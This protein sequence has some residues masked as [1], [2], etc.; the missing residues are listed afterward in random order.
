MYVIRIKSELLVNDIKILFCFGK[1]TNNYGNLIFIIEVTLIL[2]RVM[3]LQ[4]QQS[5]RKRVKYELER[6]KKCTDIIFLILRLVKTT[7]LRWLL[8]K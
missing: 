7:N 5:K 2:I 1:P 6:L 4:T 8:M 3:Y